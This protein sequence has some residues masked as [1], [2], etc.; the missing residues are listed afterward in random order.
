METTVVDTTPTQRCRAVLTSGLQC[1]NRALEG[2]DCCYEHADHWF[3]TWPEE[4]EAPRVPL[5]QDEAA[6][7]YVLTMVVHGIASNRLDA[8]RARSITYACQVIRSTFPRPAA[9]VAKNSEEKPVVHEPVVAVER[10]PAGQPMGERQPYVGPT[11]AFEPQWSFA[12]Y[13]YESECEMYKRPLPTCAADMPP[14]GWLTPEEVKEPFEEF[15]KRYHTRAD[16]LR[17]QAE[18]WDRAHPEAARALAEERARNRPRR[19]PDPEQIVEPDEDPAGSEDAES[20]GNLD[21]NASACGRGEGGG[22][23]GN[24]PIRRPPP[25]ARCLAIADR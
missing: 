21:F 18:A 23:A 10:T 5:L 15:N 11:G 7:R 12:K 6:L 9:R 14:A 25:A 19:D 24:L 8:T 1:L 20:P 17:D 22:V 4:G 16:S 3:P 2:E 13:L